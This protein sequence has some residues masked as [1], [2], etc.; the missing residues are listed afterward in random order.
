M[1]PGASHHILLKAVQYFVGWIWKL[2]KRLKGS[3]RPRQIRVIRKQT[4]T[5]QIQRVDETLIELPDESIVLG[6]PWKTKG[7]KPYQTIFDV[8]SLSELD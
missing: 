4:Y 7:N 6:S 8:K 3:K 5:I 2:L 1:W